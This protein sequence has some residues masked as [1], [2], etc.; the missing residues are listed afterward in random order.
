MLVKNKKIQ[1]LIS[2]TIHICINN[3]VEF[4]L[5]NTNKVILSGM[6]CNGYFEADLESG[7]FIMGIKKPQKE[8]LPI[9]VHESCHLDQWLENKKKFISGDGIELIDEWLN[10]KNVNKKNLKAAIEKS[11]KLELDCEKRSVIKIKKYNLPINESVYIQMA[12]SYMYF[13]N[14]VFENR[15]WVAQ[16]K[17]LFRK[18]IYSLAP[19]EWQL[20]YNTTPKNL[21]SAFNKYLI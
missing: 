2:D 16:G 7:K 18:E 20:N 5:T 3:N 10:G 4:N 13:Y 15:K 19:K 1:K 17:T 9:F 21:N 14:W 8:W 6:E 12:N 11:K